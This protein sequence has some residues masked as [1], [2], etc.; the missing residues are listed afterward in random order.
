MTRSD[1]ELGLGAKVDV[2]GTGDTELLGRKFDNESGGGEQ[3]AQ[4]DA[5][6]FYLYVLR[7]EIG[8]DMPTNGIR[9]TEPIRIIS[10]TKWKINSLNEIIAEWGVSFVL[11]ENCFDA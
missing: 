8:R 10:A 3:M 4:R 5:L 6:G 11:V 7:R 1:D 2:V 9:F